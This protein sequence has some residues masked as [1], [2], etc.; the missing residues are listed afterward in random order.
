MSRAGEEMG[1]YGWRSMGWW[2]SVSHVTFYFSPTED[3]FF[4]DDALDTLVSDRLAKLFD[5]GFSH[6]TQPADAFAH[7]ALTRPIEFAFFVFEVRLVLFARK[8]TAPE[9]PGPG[10]GE[11]LCED[12]DVQVLGG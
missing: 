7:L 10:H 11:M 8:Q 6:E 5:H 4:L 9:D 2:A 3:V 1:W 12:R